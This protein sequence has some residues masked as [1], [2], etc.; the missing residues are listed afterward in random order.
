M[1][2]DIAEFEQQGCFPPSSS[3]SSS[4][5]QTRAHK[6]ASD[7]LHR[8]SPFS[9]AARWSIFLAS[10][11]LLYSSCAKYLIM[12]TVQFNQLFCHL[13][14]TEHQL[15]LL[16]LTK[17]N[18]RGRLERKKWKTCMQSGHNSRRYGKHTCSMFQ[19]SSS[20]L[21]HISRGGKVYIIFARVQKSIFAFV[22][23]A[24]HSHLLN[25]PTKA[26]PSEISLN[27]FFTPPRWCW[28]WKKESFFFFFFFFPFC[29]QWPK[30]WPPSFLTPAKRLGR[31]FNLRSN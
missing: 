28:W 27:G 29:Q 4:R 24:F 12:V 13:D 19:C 31:D 21:F 17:K 18:R 8:Y 9:V 23:T 26:S 30:P 10:F 7:Y 14:I 6:R 1:I 20:S 15:Y 5:L 11:L 22:Q 3:S 16:L 25:I 2:Y